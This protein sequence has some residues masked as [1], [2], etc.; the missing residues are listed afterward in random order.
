VDAGLYHGDGSFFVDG[1]A[2]RNAGTSG[3]GGIDAEI[4]DAAPGCAPLAACCSTLSSASQGLCNEVV[5]SGNSSDCATELTQLQ[6]GGDCTGVSIL[7]SQVQVAPNRIVSDGTTLFWTTTA[8]PG[9]AAMPVGGGAVTVLLDAPIT[10]EVEAEGNYSGLLAVD[11][12]NVYLLNNNSLIRIPKDGSGATLVNDSA[13]PVLVATTL[14]SVAYWVESE[15]YGPPNPLVSVKTASLQGGPVSVL[16]QLN[17]PGPGPYYIGATSSTVFVGGWGMSPVDFPTTSGV[18]A[19]GPPTLMGA[20]AQTCFLL[21]SDTSA[22]YCGPQYSGSNIR[23]ASD[24]T[25]STVGPVIYS[26]TITPSPI[27]FDDTYAYWV[28]NATAGTIMKAPKAG[29]GTA[30]I[31][32]HDTNPTAIAVDANSVY[33]SDQAGYIKSVPK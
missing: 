2:Y 3:H 23:I 15:S 27:V 28:D 9:L 17:Y 30:T 32:A 16:G 12:V 5:A 10:N 7:A 29:G 25:I 26:S 22:V 4:I 31:V 21:T 13:V 20:Q 33:W 8:T 11:S 24:G 1:G 18:P 19:G 6:N 14:G